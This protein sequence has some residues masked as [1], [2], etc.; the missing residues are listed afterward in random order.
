MAYI[1]EINH[2]VLLE[3][4]GEYM[5]RILC[6]SFL[7]EAKY[8]KEAKVVAWIENGEILC[9]NIINQ[10]LIIKGKKYAVK[11]IAII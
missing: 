7:S 4:C 9:S 3:S 8:K 6:Y 11:L 1:L 2:G 10:N 5:V